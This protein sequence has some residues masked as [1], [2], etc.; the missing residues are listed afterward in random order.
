MD[1]RKIHNSI[2]EKAINEERKRN[3]GVYYEAHH[4][5]PR[6]LGGTNKKS[7]MVLLTAREHYI[8]H[9][10]LPLIYIKEDNVDAYHKMNHALHR[11]LYS[12][13]S[14]GYKISSR[15]YGKIKEAHAVSISK[16]L[17]GITRSPENRE[18][19]SSGLKK[20][21]ENNPGNFEGKSHSVETLKHMSE[22]QS[23]ENNPMH[24]KTRT[25]EERKKISDSMKGKKK[26]AE[27]I[28]K[29][30]DRKWSDEKKKQISESIKLW[31]AKR[32][33]ER[34]LMVDID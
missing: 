17:T 14:E 22:K 9:K 33:A 11:F 25:E 23:G 34:E 1:Y 2:I 6:S 20:Y 7:N 18:N 21:Y 16:A 27:T 31:H 28:Q 19:I 30:K 29:F 15:D 8:I 13:N 4:I 10:C 12:K 26:S 5:L 24:G 3:V 32:K